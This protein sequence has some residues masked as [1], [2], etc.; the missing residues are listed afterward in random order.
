VARLCHRVHAHASESLVRLVVTVGI[1]RV[2]PPRAHASLLVAWCGLAGITAR[3]CFVRPVG[4]ATAQNG[5]DPG[6]LPPIVR[7]ARCIDEDVGC[8]SGTHRRQHMYTT[9]STLR[10]NKFLEATVPQAQPVGDRVSASY[11]RVARSGS[12]VHAPSA[13]GRDPAA[14]LCSVQREASG[15][16]ARLG[17][18]SSISI[19]ANHP[20]NT[21]K[22]RQSAKGRAPSTANVQRHA[23]GST[24]PPSALGLASLPWPRC[25]GPTRAP[26]STLRMALRYLMDPGLSGPTNSLANS[27]SCD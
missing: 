19:N 10:H 16:S 17:A 25:L 3:S 5:P 4:T 9:C 20:N 6:I 27:S 12:Y 26:S 1:G 24:A 18:P 23:N 15:R 14:R 8:R 7:T 2:L 13:P 21:I 22:R 11:T